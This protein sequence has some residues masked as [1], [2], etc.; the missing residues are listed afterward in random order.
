MPLSLYSPML[1]LTVQT[2]RAYDVDTDALM[3]EYGLDP[4]LVANP[5]ARF[6]MDQINAF[7]DRLAEQIKDPN[8]GLDAARFW[9]PSQMGALGYAWLTSDTLLAAFKRYARF[10]KAISD[11]V[12]L[13]VH[14]DE[15]TVSLSFTYLR[16]EASQK[17]RIDG[18]LATLIA[19]IRANAGP[20]F[21]PITVSFVFEEPEDTAPYYALFQCPVVFSASENS[22]AI[23]AEDALALRPSSNAQL[24]KLNDQFMLEYIAKL[25]KDNIV[26]RVK[27]AITD[28]LASGRISDAIVAKKLFMAER[29]LQRR[30]RENGTTFKK[31]LTQVRIDLADNYIRD[32]NLSLNEISFLLGFSELSSFSRAFKHWKG[33]SPREYRQ[34]KQG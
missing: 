9:H 10:I 16:K 7:Y 12:R 20:D 32:S 6:R 14:E 17:F 4:K 33:R 18:A 28:E 8:F 5:N 19:M 21:H 25:D 11:A 3:R 2:A 22:L 34:A 13:D 24:V 27:V 1:D 31:L 29:T 15:E 30:L 23:T 26:E